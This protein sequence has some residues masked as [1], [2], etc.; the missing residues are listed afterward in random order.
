M[1]QGEALSFRSKR[2][3]ATGVVATGIHVLIAFVGVRAG[4]LHPALA[5]ALASIGA[6]LFSYVMH[7]LWSFSSTLQIWSFFRFV[8]V[9]LGS[10]I[11]AAAIAAAA[12]GLGLNYWAGIALVVCI[13]PVLSFSAHHFWTYRA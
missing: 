7:T 10:C 4:D 12:E 11:L 8:V 1:E 3:A 5:N 9:S 13:I 6:T 2:F